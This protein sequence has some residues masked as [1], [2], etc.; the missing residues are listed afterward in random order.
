MLSSIDL[1]YKM[2]EYDE[3]R[4]RLIFDMRRSTDFISQS[5]CASTGSAVA[6]KI[7]NESR[8]FLSNS[9]W[10]ATG[11]KSRDHLTAAE[12][13]GGTKAMTGAETLA[14]RGNASV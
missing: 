8:D 11:Y 6:L 3:L 5:V 7:S 2:S 9:N 10:I 13:S 12:F 4:E 1:F 14:C